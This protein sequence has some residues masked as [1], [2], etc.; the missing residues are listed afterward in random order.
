MREFLLLFPYLLLL[1]WLAFSIRTLIRSRDA[2]EGVNPYAMESI[3][4]VFTT[5]GVLGTFIGIA[6]GLYNFNVDNIDASLPELLE[7]LK[8]AFI[9]SIIGISLSLIFARLIDLSRHKS[10]ADEEEAEEELEALNKVVAHLHDLKE[11][12][13]K[14]F[15]FLARYLSGE[16]EE[17]LGT[18]FSKIR[19]AM[20]DSSNE[21]SGRMQENREQLEAIRATLGGDHETS[22]VVQLQRLRDEQFQIASDNR[23]NVAKMNENISKSRELIAVKFE[24]FTELLE[25]GNTEALVKAIENVIGGFNE[26]LSE[27]IDRLVKE[28]FEELNRSVQ[29]LNQWQMEN[30][31]QVAKLI[32]QFRDV[33]DRLQVSSETLSSIAENT[34]K[35][36]NEDSILKR[37]I[38]ELQQVMVDNTLFRDS[39]EQLKS[40]SETMN[41]STTH[42]RESSHQLDE[43]I[44]KEARFADAVEDLIDSLKEIEKLRDDSG[45]FWADIKEKMEEG[46]GV[47]EGGNEL[48]MERVNSLEESFQKRLNTSFKSLDKILQ[49]M[50]MEYARRING[51]GDELVL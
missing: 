20:R 17:S 29:R 37:L 25:K 11:D 5:L 13:R 1:G 10:E 6:V 46:V 45:E 35:L 48:L 12:Q 14:G 42:L 50:V 24:E 33:S 38:E 44:T 15:A 39:L 34:N 31:E 28:N 7:G 40:S 8:L 27:L 19:N 41:E 49:S 21:I 18:Q 3:P 16:S 51:N 4:S 32:D 26:R 30:K 9:S 47:I 22:L 43:W 36:T 2:F 23:D